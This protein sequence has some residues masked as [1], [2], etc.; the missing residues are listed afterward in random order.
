MLN[1]GRQGLGNPRR[2][3]DIKETDFY[4]FYKKN[5]KNPVE[6]KVFGQFSKKLGNGIVRLVTFDGVEVIFPWRLGT[7]YLK[8][9]ETKV[10]FDDEGN[11]DKKKM[12][13]DWGRTLKHWNGAYPTK[14]MDEIKA[15]KDKKYFYHLNEHSDGYKYI[16]YWDKVTSN[17]K[18]Q[19]F[20]NFKPIRK[21]KRE[22]TDFI[23]IT[24]NRVKYYE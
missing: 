24:N 5:S 16:W 21:I 1:F 20:Y 19:T 10:Y 23:R 11:I 2:K 17:V 3:S 14:S 22:L 18:N 9:R 6:R 7:L 4:N 13:V 12:R 8:R 15:I